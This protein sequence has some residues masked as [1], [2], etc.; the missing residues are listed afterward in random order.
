MSATVHLAARP[1]V[2]ELGRASLHAVERGEGPPVVLLHGV[3]ANARIW[4]P[5]AELLAASSR[6]IAL[7][8]RGHGLSGSAA[9]GEYG[10]KAYAADVVALAE[11]LGE[12]LTLV[13]H[14]LGARNAIEA[15]A[16]SPA[17]VAAVV[18][19]DFTPYIEPEV[20]AALGVRVAA[21]ARRFEDL[22]DVRGYLR[23]RY[24]RLP[25]QA[26][27]R[28][29]RHGY[30]PGADGR[31]HPLADPEAMQATCAGL[32]EDLAPAL[33][34][35]SGTC[36]LVRGADSALVSPAAFARTRR[37][38]PDLEAVEVAGADHYVPEEQPGALAGIVSGV[39]AATRGG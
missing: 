39:L 31:L 20:L 7:D 14:S 27:E 29:A 1:R 19:V 26:V 2:F 38:R 33:A 13:G 16:S 32:S 34:R 28:R 35:L 30:A 22:D 37:L 3:T 21:G 25:E 5:V 23:G 11:V 24:P 8:Q 12:P 36:V 9:G 15:A 17:H 18:A 10:A 4:D 6:V